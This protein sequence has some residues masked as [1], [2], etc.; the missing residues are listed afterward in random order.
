M[1]HPFPLVPWFFGCV[2]PWIRD[3]LVSGLHVWFPRITGSP[4][5]PLNRFLGYFVGAPL[6]FMGFV[7]HVPAP[8]MLVCL[9]YVAWLCFT[10]L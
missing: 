10:Y 1:V 5:V 4:F 9:G 2:F 8:L 7:V 6:V 3:S